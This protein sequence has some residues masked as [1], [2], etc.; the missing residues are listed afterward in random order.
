MGLRD[1]LKLLYVRYHNAYG[2]QTWQ[3]GDIKQGASFYKVTRP[4]D[5]IVLQDH[6]KYYICYISAT[7]RYWSMILAYGRKII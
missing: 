2:Y 4:L 1:Q 7:L 3:G 5:Y 6:M